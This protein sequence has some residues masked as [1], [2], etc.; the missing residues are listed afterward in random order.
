[1]VFAGLVCFWR[2]GATDLVSMEGMVVDGARHMLASGDWT[3]PRVYGELYTYKPALAYWLA[4]IPL[5]LAAQPSEW[6]LRLPFAACGFVM[7][8]AVLVLIGRV[9]GSRV[10]LLCATASVSGIL[11]LQKSRMMEFDATLAAG[12]GVAVAAA[13]HNLSAERQSR[14]VW[15][16]GYLALTAGF[17]S[18]G[19]PALAVYGPG[20]LAAGM[21]TG[22]FRRL[23]RWSHLLAVMAFVALTGA[24]LW[25]TYQSAGPQAFE[26]PLLEAQVRGLGGRGGEDLDAQSQADVARFV[27]QEGELGASPLGALALALA[28]PA[29]ICLAFL[30]WGILLLFALRREEWQS[31]GAE[32]L[33][34]RAA[35]GFLV[36]STLVFMAT[37]TH[38]MR[39][40]LPLCVPMGIL[41]GVVA[42]RR[43]EPGRRRSRVLFGAVA[44]VVG[45]FAGASVFAGA[46][47]FSSPPIPMPH[48]L[49]IILVGVAAGISILYLA[50]R[51]HPS[52]VVFVLTIGVL[53]AMVTEYLGVQPRRASRRSLRPQAQALARHLEPGQPVWVLGPSDVAGKHASLYFYLNRPVS[54]FRPGKRL[55]P[56]DS[57]CILTSED[58]D[59]LA[60][61]P[62]F[63]FHEIAR[64]EHVWWTYRVGTCT[65]SGDEIRAGG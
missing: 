63:V 29:L 11:F 59:K 21:A 39:Y 38:E 48:R 60:G 10:G 7:G 36:A 25:A 5:Q 2:L 46:A 41:C 19:V 51:A 58:V 13:C 3:V 40:F 14:G 12:V 44:V 33:L 57:Y 9:A 26:Q 56:A 37:R 4:A 61:S 6:M 52:R 17:L 31:G 47:L 1:M 45:I 23:L 8:L 35:A 50:K 49:A 15:V 54:S 24:Y 55:P 64:S 27:A 28:K 22:R 20:I 65:G 30:P 32:V 62:N 16:L 18:K 43:I 34:A 42:G 53:C